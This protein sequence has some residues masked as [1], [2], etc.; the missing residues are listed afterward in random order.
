MILDLGEVVERLLRGQA[1]TG[2]EESQVAPIVR[3]FVEHLG[4]VFN[5]PES[6]VL[7]MH[8]PDVNMAD[9]SPL[10]WLERGDRGWSV[11]AVMAVGQGTVA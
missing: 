11:G 5:D 10:Y 3:E 4:H 7:F 1:L 9:Q 6:A 8:A 2:P